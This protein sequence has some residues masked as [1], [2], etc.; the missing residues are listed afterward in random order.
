LVWFVYIFCAFFPSI[1]IQSYS[2]AMKI[3]GK[4]HPPANLGHKVLDGIAESGGQSR[5]V[6]CGPN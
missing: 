1:A 4:L 6:L 3:G 2:S 5:R